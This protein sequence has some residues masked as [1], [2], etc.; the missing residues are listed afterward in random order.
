MWASKARREY[1]RWDWKAAACPPGLNGKSSPIYD[2]S[3]A[4][5]ALQ[6]FQKLTGKSLAEK[7]IWALNLS[8]ILAW[9]FGRTLQGVANP[10]GYLD[11]EHYSPRA[12]VDVLFVG[13]RLEIMFHHQTA[14]LVHLLCLLTIMITAAV[15][16]AATSRITLFLLL[17]LRY[18]AIY[19]TR[20]LRI[21]QVNID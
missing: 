4:E 8:Q 10:V 7:L 3:F 13:L 17:C 14:G 9:N 16:L 15:G 19:L 2:K 6:L 20:L 12:P 5:S 18:I 11:S 21:W 1:N